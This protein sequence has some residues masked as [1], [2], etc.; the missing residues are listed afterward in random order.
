[1]YNN[2]NWEESGG[3]SGGDITTNLLRA[4]DSG[5]NFV[6]GQVPESIANG[7]IIFNP[8][9]VDW[10]G[11]FYYDEQRNLVCS[12]LQKNTSTS[13]RSVTITASKPEGA[14]WGSCISPQIFTVRQLGTGGGDTPEPGIL[15]DTCIET[16][17][18]ISSNR[19]GKYNSHIRF[20]FEDGGYLHMYCGGAAEKGDA[21]Y[22][23]RYS[24]KYNITSSESSTQYGWGNLLIF[25]GDTIPSKFR[26][27]CYNWGL[28]FLEPTDSTAWIDKSEFFSESSRQKRAYYGNSTGD[29]M[30]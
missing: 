30:D 28:A 29:P 27:L 22:G 24:S 1:M 17:I 10:L 9:S 7:G 18:N 3:G 14:D 15:T 23:G 13:E 8:N 12:Q 19:Y 16:H 11:L 26:Y 4:D 20:E 21:T 2:G 25:V 5:V 6:I